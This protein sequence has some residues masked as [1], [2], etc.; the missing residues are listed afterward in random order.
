V[1][2]TA[3]P[4]IL[5]PGVH[6]TDDGEAVEIGADDFA[7]AVIRAIPAG[8]LYR[9]GNIA[10]EIV[11]PAGGR[12][13]RL[14]TPARIR[15]LVDRHVR[16]VR[17]VKGTAVFTPMSRDHASI[18][19]D[20]AGVHE[21]VRELLIL[22]AYPCFLGDDFALAEAGWNPGHGVYYDQ[23]PELRDLDLRVSDDDIHRSLRDLMIDFPFKTDADRQ[24]FYGLLLTPMLRPALGGNAPMHMLLSPLERTGKSKLAEQVLGGIVLG[25]PTPAIQMAGT[26]EERDKRIMSQLLRS[27]TILHLDN[28]REY[29]DSAALA[30]LLTSEVYSGR[31]LGRSEVVD[32]PNHMTVVASGNNVRATGELV[33]RT[34]PI[35]LQPDTDCPEAR[36]DFVHP[37]L[38]GYVRSVRRPVVSALLA[39]VLNWRD[40][41]RALGHRPFGGFERWA[42]VVGG[43]LQH[44][45]YGLWLTNQREW[46][47]AADPFRQDLGLLVE[48]WHERHGNRGVKAAQLMSICEELDLFPGIL[49]ST[50]EKGRATQ[51]GIKVL[52]RSLDT[53]VGGYRIVTEGGAAHRFYSLEPIG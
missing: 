4:A 2:S 20:S 22:L 34:V 32:L 28:V 1:P 43:I 13:F 27:R 21:A 31:V 29:L 17:W 36:T 50:T 25:C 44:A 16:L 47:R 46:A 52:A 39:L 23:P 49:R 14:I 51:F 33:K 3:G 10:G 30:S 8:T 9:R 41:S 19:I 5:V 12:V 40:G 18:I 11:G 15:V 45:S 7:E 26:D 42:A 53:P 38:G 48:S 35:Q 6:L 24:N 37:D